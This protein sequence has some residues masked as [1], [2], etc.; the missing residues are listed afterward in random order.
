MRKPTLRVA[1]RA[2]GAQRMLAEAG[3]SV[4]GAASPAAACLSPAQLHEYETELEDERKQRALAAAAKK[5]LEGDLKD[6]ELQADSA[7]KGRE[8]A[9]KQLR[10]LQVG[11]LPRAGGG[12]EGPAPRSSSRRHGPSLPLLPVPCPGSGSVTRLLAKALSSQNR[13]LAPPGGDPPNS[14]PRLRATP[15]RQRLLCG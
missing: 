15:L 10:K 3:K 4:R 7:V 11:A 13:F 9:I 12:G 6:L 5:K 14:H 1:A 8:E 2:V